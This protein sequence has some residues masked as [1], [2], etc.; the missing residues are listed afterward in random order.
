M[1][2]RTLIVMLTGLNLFLLACLLLTSWSPPQALAQDPATPTST[3][4]LVAAEADMFND[5]V[6]LLDVQNDRLYL[7]R[8][9]YPYM[10][11]KPLV[12]KWID[13]RDLKRDF[14]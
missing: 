4:L 6:Y 13:T 3:Y 1:N 9:T 12:I 10:V 11:N 5:A 8:S 2:K 7:F 14:R